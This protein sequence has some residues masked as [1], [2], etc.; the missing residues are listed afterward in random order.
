MTL[1]EFFTASAEEAEQRE[2]WNKVVELLEAEDLLHIQR[3][4]EVE[5]RLPERA[6]SG[7]FVVLKVEEEWS[8]LRVQLMVV[9]RGFTLHGPEIATTPQPKGRALDVGRLKTLLKQAGISS[10]IAQEQFINDVRAGHA[11]GI[12]YH[13][14]LSTCPLGSHLIWS[15]FSEAGGDPFE[16]VHDAEVVRDRLGLM[17]PIGLDDQELVLLVYYVPSDVLIRY[18]TIA[19]AYAGEAWNPYFQCSNPSD[20]W[21]YTSGGHPE[22]VH[23]VVHGRH[24]VADD[25]H[26]GPVRIVD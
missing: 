17:P 14:F 18:P 22:V 5:S 19:D 9:F 12:P 7:V 23:D 26:G 13:Q 21:G 24:L 2:C 15:T 4:F 6:W 20:S 8:E 1:E 3:N 25:E 16:N 11:P 10:P